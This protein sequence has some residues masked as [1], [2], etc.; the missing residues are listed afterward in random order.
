M[1]FCSIS[2]FKTPIKLLNEQQLGLLVIKSLMLEGGEFYNVI[3]CSS[4]YII[5]LFVIFN[6]VGILVHTGDI[7]ERTAFVG[8]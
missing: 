7:E 3:D 5:G 6:Y 8:I 2:G 4:P 1:V